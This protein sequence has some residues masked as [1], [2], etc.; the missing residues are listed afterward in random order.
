MPQIEMHQELVSADISPDHVNRAAGCS[1]DPVPVVQ[2]FGIHDLNRQSCLPEQFGQQRRFVAL[3]SVER[4]LQMENRDPGLAFAPELLP[5]L[6]QRLD[7]R[8]GP[9]GLG[10][11]VLILLFQGFH[12]P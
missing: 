1:Q 10:E 3:Y 7:H 4:Q 9:A 11:L 5:S 8:L 2:V 6:K 12:H